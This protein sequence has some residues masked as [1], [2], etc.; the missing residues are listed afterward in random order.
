MPVTD[1]EA[2]A[3]GQDTKALEAAAQTVRRYRQPRLAAR[4]LSMADAIARGD[5]TPIS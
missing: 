2:Y 4:L 3:V 5:V 1:D